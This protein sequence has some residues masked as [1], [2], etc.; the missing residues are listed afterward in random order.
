MFREI[1]R[2]AQEHLTEHPFYA[3][4]AIDHHANTWKNCL[5][6]IGKEKLTV[7]K[8]NLKIAAWWHD[9]ERNDEKC[10]LLKQ[11]MSELRFRNEEIE[12]VTDI[13]NGHTYGREQVSLESKVLY[14]ADKLEYVSEKRVETLLNLFKDG[15]IS[16][17]RFKDYK[18]TWSERIKNVK[19]N[20][21]FFSSKDLFDRK[22]AVLI[23]HAK[24]N[25]LLADMVEAVI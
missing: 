6:I 17:A 12:K 14:D 21:H 20:L 8:R 4:H 3:L 2:N 23:E 5:W 16:D 24:T 25:S 15:Y 7:D 19:S 10:L 9:V 13:I 1:I 22:L 11:T 18:K